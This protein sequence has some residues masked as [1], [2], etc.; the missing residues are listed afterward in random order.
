MTRF[1]IEEVVFQIRQLSTECL[2]SEFIIRVSTASGWTTV[3]DITTA[4]AVEL[5]VRGQS[6]WFGDIQRRGAGA[7]HTRA[8]TDSRS[9]SSTYGHFG[10]RGF[11]QYGFLWVRIPIDFKSAWA[12]GV[13]GCLT[14]CTGGVHD[15]DAP[16]SPCTSQTITPV[17]EL[18]D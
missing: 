3:E 18:S 8:P 13:C 7:Y 14:W 15:D 6:G 12:H 16:L 1:W 4:V 17:G 9:K 2:R 5:E 11:L 10:G